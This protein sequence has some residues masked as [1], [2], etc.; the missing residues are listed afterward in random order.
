[1]GSGRN[2]YDIRD[3]CVGAQ[4]Y[5]DAV[6][7]DTYLSQ[8]NVKNALG[9]HLEGNFSDCNVIVYFQ[10]GFSGDSARPFQQYVTELLNKE[11]PVLIYVGDKD[12][13]CNW[14]GNKAWTDA[15]PWNGAEAY[16][17]SPTEQ[18]ITNHPVKNGSAGTVKSAN[19]LTFLRVFDAGH[20]VPHDQPPENALAMLNSWIFSGAIN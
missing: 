6:Y 17:H 12:Y 9:A 19:N 16:S 20:G 5:P 8:E 13:I 4:C 1:M 18:W 14:L 2:E 3:K 10:F 15:L 11:V 7:K